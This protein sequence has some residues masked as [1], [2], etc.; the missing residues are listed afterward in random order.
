ME[1]QGRRSPPPTAPF[2]HSSPPCGSSTA[3]P[4]P[5]EFFTGL[6]ANGAQIRDSNIAI[7][8][9]VDAGTVPVGLVNH[10]Y[11]GEIAKER[12]ITVDAMKAKLHFFTPR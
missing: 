3:R 11:L 7:V 10:Y 2:R 9:D 6:K 4:G 1:G 8:K 5:K 12:G